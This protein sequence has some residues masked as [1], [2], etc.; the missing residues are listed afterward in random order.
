MHARRDF[1]YTASHSNAEGDGNLLGDGADG[2]RLA[3]LFVGYVRIG[4]R[5]GSGE[6][7]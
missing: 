3:G 5:I 2:R 7:Q 1:E 6:K 4:E